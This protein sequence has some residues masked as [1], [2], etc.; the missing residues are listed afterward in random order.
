MRG[1]FS[2]IYVGGESLPGS[3]PVL[4]AMGLAKAKPAKAAKRSEILM[5]FILGNRSNDLLDVSRENMGL[6]I[7]STRDQ[8]C[9][10]LSTPEAKQN[11]YEIITISSSEAC[12]SSAQYDR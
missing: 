11:E 12:I 1:A 4:V 5:S 6:W 8:K 10:V 9:P 3:T 7:F 2:S